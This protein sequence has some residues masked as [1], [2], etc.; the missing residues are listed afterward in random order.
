MSP[1]SSFHAATFPPRTSLASN[2]MGSCP[3]S[4][5]YLAVLS[6]AKP[7]QGKVDA[8][9]SIHFAER[10]KERRAFLKRLNILC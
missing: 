6:P 3:A 10:P 8:S 2:I 4:A 9:Q 5:R 7:A 1:S